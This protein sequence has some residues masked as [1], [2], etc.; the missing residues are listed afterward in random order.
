MPLWLPARRKKS[1]FDNPSTQKHIP[2]S[3]PRNVVEEGWSLAA[4]CRMRFLRAGTPSG[5]PPLLLIHGIVAYSFS[6]RFNIPAF[7]RNRVVYA[8]DLPGLGQSERVRGL[9]C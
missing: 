7:S 9:D 8:V 6:W 3:E 1:Q 5:R 2:D 4:G